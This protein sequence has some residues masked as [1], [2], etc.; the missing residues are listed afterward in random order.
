MVQ[1]L[2]GSWNLTEFR[3]RCV[4]AERPDEPKRCPPLQK[5]IAF[6]SLRIGSAQAIDE[7]AGYRLGERVLD[8]LTSGLWAIHCAGRFVLLTSVWSGEVISDPVKALKARPPI[9]R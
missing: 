3:R 8:S 7:R 6:R 4:A 9:A 1:E 2:G 5:A